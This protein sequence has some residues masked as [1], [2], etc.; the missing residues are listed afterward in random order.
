M[1][2]KKSIKYRR[3][4][5]VRLT[6]EARLL[7]LLREE[8][9]MSIRE[10]AQMI[11][12]SESYLRHIEKG[13]LDIPCEIRLREI[14]SIYQVTLRQYKARLKGFHIQKDPRDELY[15]ITRYADN[16]NIKVIL[17]MA[18]AVLNIKEEG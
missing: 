3:T 10:V 8:E 2:K 17:K 18:K 16:E 7:T 11:G 14:L 9:K 15:K 4:S 6:N 13:R 12:K 1:K 5:E